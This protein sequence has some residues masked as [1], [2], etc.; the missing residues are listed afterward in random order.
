MKTHDIKFGWCERC[1]QTSW[2]ARGSN[3]HVCA[4]C[5]SDLIPRDKLPR[6]RRKLF[7]FQSWSNGL[8]LRGLSGLSPGGAAE[9]LG[10]HRTMIDKLVD[11]KVLERSIYNKDGYYVVEISARSIDRALANK[12]KTGKWTGTGEEKKTGVWKWVRKVS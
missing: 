7:D 2:T 6:I 5:Q 3:A 12:Q 8:S 1:G 10:C 4:V 11:M 9:E